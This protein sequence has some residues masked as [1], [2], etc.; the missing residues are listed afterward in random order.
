MTFTDN[1]AAAWP[2]GVG[3]DDFAQVTRQAFEDSWTRNS[4]FNEISSSIGSIFAETDAKMQALRA[5]IEGTITQ[6][7]F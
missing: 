4:N 3:P 5:G 6:T 1:G 7:Y 2:V